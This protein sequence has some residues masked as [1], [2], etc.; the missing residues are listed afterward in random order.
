LSLLAQQHTGPI[1][2]LA[3][4]IR[5]PMFCL[6]HHV[7]EQHLYHVSVSIFIWCSCSNLAPARAQNIE[8]SRHPRQ[9]HWEEPEGNPSRSNLAPARAQNIE[10]SRSP[11]QAHWEEPAG[12]PPTH[13]SNFEDV[14]EEGM[15]YAGEEEPRD[16]ADPDEDELWY[17]LTTLQKLLKSDFSLVILVPTVLPVTNDLTHH[18][19]RS[20]S[21]LTN[22]Q[23]LVPM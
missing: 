20:A 3:Q 9:A 17:V 11:P 19:R 5:Y 15:S 1:P 22:V 6:R 12:N 10:Q 16:T 13:N 23:N 14:D 8:Q 21:I 18:Y 4:G 2:R 7:Q